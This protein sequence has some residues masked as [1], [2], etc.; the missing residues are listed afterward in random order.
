ML[1]MVTL[2]SF[3]VFNKLFSLQLEEDVNEVIFALNSEGHTDFTS[4]DAYNQLQK[5]LNVKN[6]EMNRT[7]VDSAKKI[8]PLD[9]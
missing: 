6:P 1:S 5:L 9:G 8:R 2:V 3:Q 4:L 7:I